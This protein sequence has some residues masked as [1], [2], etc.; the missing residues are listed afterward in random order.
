MNRRCCK[1]FKKSIKYSSSYLLM[2]YV[3]LITSKSTMIHWYDFLFFIHK[4]T[5]ENLFIC[6]CMDFSIYNQILG[7][8]KNE[9]IQVFCYLMLILLTYLAEA[10]E[11][12]KKGCIDT[13][14][15][16]MIPF[17]LGIASN[18]S[19]NEWYMVD[20]NASTP[21]LYALDNLE[22]L[23]INLENKQSLL[24]SH[25][26]LI[27]GIIILSQVST[28]V[29]VLLYFQNRITYSL[30]QGVV[31]L[32]SWK[33]GKWSADVQLLATMILLSMKAFFVLASIAAKQRFVMI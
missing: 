18:C 29:T 9:A 31:L 26:C 3:S 2:T 20:C 4:I 25:K 28:L 22:V 15:E 14:G 13:C 19:L 17:P 11:Y 24:M 23:S 27:S 21:Y 5:L 16:V 1:A 7:D 10:I 33:I 32:L 6:K 12:A 30:L 8:N